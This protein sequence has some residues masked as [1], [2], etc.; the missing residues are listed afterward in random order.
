MRSNF[1]IAS[2]VTHVESSTKPTWRSDSQQRA[3]MLLAMTSP[4]AEP[5]GSGKR[6]SIP[7]SLQH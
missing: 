7:A 5:R 3:A 1:D 6:I 4:S 2:C